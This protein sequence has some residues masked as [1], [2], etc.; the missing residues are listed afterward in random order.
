MIL[1]RS[2]EIAIRA[3]VFL[4]RIKS[5]SLIN[6]SAIAQSLQESPSFMAKILQKMA[7]NGILISRKGPSGGFKLARPP[8]QITLLQIVES[9]EGS[10]KGNYCAPLHPELIAHSCGYHQAMHG[11]EEHIRQYLAS[12]NLTTLANMPHP[13]TGLMEGTNGMRCKLT[14]A[15]NS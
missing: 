12:W 4:L 8:Q 5:D 15:K 9:V 3:C 2:S 1:N 11:L 6:P 7:T 13:S 14:Y 10:I